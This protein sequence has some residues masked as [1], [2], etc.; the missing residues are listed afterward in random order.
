MK[1]LT[2]TLTRGPGRHTADLVR[3]AARHTASLVRGAAR[4]LGTLLT[5]YTIASEEPTTPD[6]EAHGLATTAYGCAAFGA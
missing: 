5:P 2:G 4:H 6:T 3:G 1:L